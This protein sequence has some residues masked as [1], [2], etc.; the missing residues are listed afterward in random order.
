M[1][2][3]IILALISFSCSLFAQNQTNEAGRKIGYWKLTGA[4]KPMPGFDESTVVEEGEF[5]EGR[6]I[7]VWKAYYPSGKLKSEITHD[8]GR[9]KGPYTTYYENGQI[10]EKG[11]WGLNK[12][13][14]SSPATTKTDKYSKISLLTKLE[15]EMELKN[16]TM[17]MVS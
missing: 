6:K 9:P 12:N 13:M 16:T 8:N 3:F 4:D 11:N 10:E 7:G 17:K 2:T 5:K 15:R 14:A 1:R